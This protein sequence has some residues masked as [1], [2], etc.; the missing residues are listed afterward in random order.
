MQRNGKMER[1]RFIIKLWLVLCQPCFSMPSANKRLH[2]CYPK[3]TARK[4]AVK[5]NLF[6][7]SGFLKDFWFS[8]INPTIFFSK[9]YKNII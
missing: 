2:R 4:C 1:L 8:I 6:K 9:K 5:K 3:I 7:E